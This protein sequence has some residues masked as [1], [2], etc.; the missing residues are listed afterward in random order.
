[1]CPI[2]CQNLRHLLSVHSS[3][4]VDKARRKIIDALSWTQFPCHSCG[5]FPCLVIQERL[6]HQQGKHFI[7]FWDKIVVTLK[8]CASVQWFWT[9]TFWIINP[10]IILLRSI[11]H[12]L[13]LDC[14]T[15]NTIVAENGP[16]AMKRQSLCWVLP[17]Q[18]S[19]PFFTSGHLTLDNKYISLLIG[20]LR[21]S[22]FMLSLSGNSLM[23]PHF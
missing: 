6:V 16:L 11:R 12:F 5:Y 20:H 9:Y 22:K 3:N 18:P 10:S 4:S 2:L 7:S 23:N 8:K 1:M 14:F 13:T 15:G 21:V 19:R 17:S